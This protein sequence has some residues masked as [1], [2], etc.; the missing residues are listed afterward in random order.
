MQLAAF[1]ALF[2]AV[3]V[4]IYAALCYN[5]LVML[6]H[7]VHKAWSNIDV[8]L[9]QRHDELPK[10]VAACQAYMNHEQETLRKVIDA[11]GFVAAAR[12]AKDIP[13]LGKAEGLLRSG[14]G[15]LFAL[16]ESYPDLKANESF[17][18]LQGRISGLESAIADRREFYNEAVNANNV[19]IDQFPDLFIARGF[20]FVA[21]AVLHFEA[22]EKKDVDLRVLFQAS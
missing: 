3:V 14:L 5:R 10:L 9:K 8:L 11:R 18:H 7:A 21:F 13:A 2:A 12:A 22:E 16:V 20:K 19:A 17:R 4:L 1:A 6:K 15:E